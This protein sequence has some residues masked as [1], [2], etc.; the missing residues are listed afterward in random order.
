M[1]K[2]GFFKCVGLVLLIILFGVLCFLIGYASKKQKTIECPESV[3]NINEVIEKTENEFESNV[4]DIDKNNSDSIDNIT[5]S[6]VDPNEQFVRDTEFHDN[7]TGND[8]FNVKIIDGNVII[9]D[10]EKTVEYTGYRAKY[11]YTVGF[12]ECGQTRLIF[13]TEDG[14]LY[15]I[16]YLYNIFRDD[17]RTIPEKMADNVKEIVSRYTFKDVINDIITL[18]YSVK[19]LSND[20]QYINYYWKTF[21]GPYTNEELSNIVKEY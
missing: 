7:C 9:T 4:V 1:R 5:E 20:N 17:H 15:K 13:L 19:V 2:E 3:V 18:N 12:M 11:L 8:K 10:G 14:Y 6:V 21:V 16:D